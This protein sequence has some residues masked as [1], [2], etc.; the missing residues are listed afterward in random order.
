LNRVGERIIGPFHKAVK[1]SSNYLDIRH[2][3]RQY[4]WQDLDNQ[5]QSAQFRNTKM[6]WYRM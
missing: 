1:I 4:F 2:A 5:L 3:D 6:A